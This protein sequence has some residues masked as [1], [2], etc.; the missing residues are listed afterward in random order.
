MPEH[1]AVTESRTYSIRC[2]RGISETCKYKEEITSSRP[3]DGNPRSR[4]AAAQ[5]FRAEGWTLHTSGHATCTSCMAMWEIADPTS[6]PVP[7]D[8]A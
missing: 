6:E 3:D 8:D 7:E 4:S 2:A 5:H 1:T